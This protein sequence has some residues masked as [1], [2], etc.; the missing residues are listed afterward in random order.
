MDQPICIT[1]AQVAEAFVKGH[2]RLHKVDVPIR[3]RAYQT[4]WD[5]AAITGSSLQ[6]PFELHAYG[7][8]AKHHARTRCV[9]RVPR[10]LTLSRLLHLLPLRLTCLCPP[11]RLLT[12][13]TGQ[14]GHLSLL[15]HTSCIPILVGPN[16]G[17]RCPTHARTWNAAP[18]MSANAATHAHATRVEGDG[19]PCAAATATRMKP[20]GSKRKEPMSR[21]EK[22]VIRP[23]IAT[24]LV[25]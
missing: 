18:S 12:W 13:W 8:C 19:L 10:A 15:V 2:C 23:F 22:A 9:S 4:A 17:L 14:A 24:M 16:S 21:G 1:A 3:T 25:P 5:E 11:T 20:E 7:H 6:S